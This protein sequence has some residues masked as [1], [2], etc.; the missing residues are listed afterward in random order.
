MTDPLLIETSLEGR[1]VCL[2]LCGEL[3]Y[4]T[5]PV[6]DEHLAHVIGPTRPRLV[7][8]VH[9]LQF[10]D[11]VG[12]SALI[13]AQRRVDLDGGRMILHGVHGMLERILRMTG[14]GVLFTIVADGVP[15]RA[16]QALGGDAERAGEPA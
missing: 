14:A 16:D 3:T 9:R 12:L 2:A 1:S 10:C 13:G 15:D 4:G 6:F 11:S 5:V 8:D 7:L